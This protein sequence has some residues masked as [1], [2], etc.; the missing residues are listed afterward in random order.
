LVIKKVLG[1]LIGFVVLFV[2]LFDLLQSAV[3]PST[4]F[5]LTIV[6]LVG[7]PAVLGVFL[8]RARRRDRRA[9]AQRF[10][11]QDEIRRRGEAAMEAHGDRVG[12]R[13]YVDWRR[14]D[15][16]P[17]RQG[18]VVEF[19]KGGLRGD[20]G[21][22]GRSKKGKARHG[23]R[24]SMFVIEFVSPHTGTPS[25]NQWGQIGSTPLFGHWL[26]L[27]EIDEYGRYL[28]PKQGFYIDKK[29]GVEP[30]GFAYPYPGMGGQDDGPRPG[31]SHAGR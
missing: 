5:V 3:G 16:G 27:R 30:Q 14:P 19:P 10:A 13:C 4:A 23:G 7:G 22:T 24:G 12:S 8:I 29:A 20:K 6:I 26:D 15:P 17:L 2:I 21:V 11:Q 18:L 1:A 28:G 31:Y 25:E 9:V